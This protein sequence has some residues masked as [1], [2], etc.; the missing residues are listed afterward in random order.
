MQKLFFKLGLFEKQ[1]RNGLEFAT[2]DFMR[3]LAV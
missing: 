3:Q 2:L 1:L